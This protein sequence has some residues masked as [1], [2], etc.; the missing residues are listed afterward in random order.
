M[1]KRAKKKSAA[2]NQLD[3]T[4]ALILGF[5]LKTI[6]L[7]HSAATLNIQKGKLP[8]RTSV[9]VNEQAGV[10]E[11]EKLIK[12][13]LRCQVS[14]D[15]EEG[16]GS[17][18]P[19]ISIECVY[20]AVYFSKTDSFPSQSQIEAE[21]PSFLASAMFHLW[22]FVRHYAFWTTAQMGLRPLTLP[23]YFPSTAAGEIGSIADTGL[24]PK[25]AKTPS[26]E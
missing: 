3:G 1:K 19:P 21:S 24:A 13:D 20:Q 10:S 11:D 18:P 23:M 7:I 4:R 9:V 2:K 15:Y 22:P 26:A 8:S 25:R 17:T 12:V 5:D 14:I 16:L 6:R